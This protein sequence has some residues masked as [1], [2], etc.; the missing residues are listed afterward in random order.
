M[1]KHS[2]ISVFAAVAVSV[3]GI[4][5]VAAYAAPPAGTPQGGVPAQLAAINQTLQDL[6][7]EIS[8]GFDFISASL[9]NVITFIDENVVNPL[10]GGHD[11]SDVVANGDGNVFERLEFLQ[12]QVAVL[13]DDGDG[14]GNGGSLFGA[15]RG[16][17]NGTALGFIGGSQANGGY[18]DFGDGTAVSSDRYEG[19]WTLC[20]LSNNFCGTGNSAAAVKDETTALVWS[21]RCGGLGTNCFPLATTSAEVRYGWANAVT[22][23]QSLGAGWELPHQ[24]QLMQAYIDGSYGNLE[25]IGQF[26]WYWTSTTAG[27]F[28]EN[29][30]YGT[31]NTGFLS[32]TGKTLQNMSARCVLPQ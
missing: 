10:N 32:F 25:N 23:C 28:G 22:A 18:I 4:V 24:R 13:Q 21:H 11:S 12:T 1:K 20:G 3:A 8:G 6:G 31:L 27:A 26:A 14:N 30:A 7:A 5:T 17:F 19:P 15:L 2:I 9:D 29:A 16:L